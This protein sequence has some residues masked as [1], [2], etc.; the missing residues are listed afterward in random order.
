MA[1]DLSP[2]LKQFIAACESEVPLLIHVAPGTDPAELQGL[3]VTVDRVIASINVVAGRVGASESAVVRVLEA[4]SVTD[5]EPDST[6][7][8]LSN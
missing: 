6:A 1:K 3:G 8:A 2:E 7:T 5:I 4:E